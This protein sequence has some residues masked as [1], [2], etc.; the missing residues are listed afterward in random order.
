MQTKSNIRVGRNIRVARTARGWTQQELALRTGMKHQA[1]SRVESE[2]FDPRLS[3]LRRIAGAFGV[4]VS[5]LL[6]GEQ[7]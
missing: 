6:A 2:E 7:P 1:V 4:S 5:E 3:T